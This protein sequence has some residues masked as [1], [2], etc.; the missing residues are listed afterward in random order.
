[1]QDSGKWQTCN[2][3]TPHSQRAQLAVFHR[4]RHTGEERGAGSSVLACQRPVL[5]PVCP[6]GQSRGLRC[7]VWCPQRPGRSPPLPAP[8]AEASPRPSSARAARGQ[9]PAPKWRPELPALPPQDGGGRPGAAGRSR[10]LAWGRPREEPPGEGR[11]GPG[12]PGGAS[13]AASGCCPCLP[14]SPRPY[15]WRSVAWPRLASSPY[16]CSLSCAL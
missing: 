12:A 2:V 13:G 14:G 15:W 5:T 10:G 7:F 1:M 16:R 3:F 11:C 8:G 9:G 6:E 4:Q